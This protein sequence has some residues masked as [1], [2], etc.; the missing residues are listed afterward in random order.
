MESRTQSRC[1]SRIQF[2]LSTHF[3]YNRVNPNWNNQLDITAA[4]VKEFADA[5]YCTVESVAYTA[6]K[7]LIKVRG[8]S[9]AKADTIY[10]AASRIVAK[11]FTTATDLHMKR[12][13]LVRLTTTGSREL[14]KILGGGIETG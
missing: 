2:V 8:I 3:S 13:D 9:E 7:Q 10:F 1:Q 6:K 14:D 5:G 11:G 12:S 4:D